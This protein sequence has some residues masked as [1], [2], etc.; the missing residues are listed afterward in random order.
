MVSNTEIAEI[1]GLF[2]WTGDDIHLIAGTCKTCGSRFFP[3]FYSQHT[4]DCTKRDVVDLILSSDGVI[5]SYT[6]H[7]YPPPPPCVDMSPYAIALVEFPEGIQVPGMIIGREFDQIKIG[8]KVKVVKEAL[9]V[10]EEGTKHL[11]WM[12]KLV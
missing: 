4:P 8:S 10:D 6:I 9:F 1:E 12:Y 2:T 7:H 5:K 11:T 3:K